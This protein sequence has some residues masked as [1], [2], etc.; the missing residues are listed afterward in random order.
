ML[1]VVVVVSYLTKSSDQSERHSTRAVSPA[2][3]VKFVMRI[4]A[5]FLFPVKKISADASE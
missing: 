3:T 5:S 2:V 4:N 1:F